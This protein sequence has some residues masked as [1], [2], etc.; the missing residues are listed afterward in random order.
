MNHAMRW[1]L[2]VAVLA[3]ASAAPAAEGQADGEK[4]AAEAGSFPKAFEVV[5]IGIPEGRGTSLAAYVNEKGQVV[6]L[7]NAAP[8]PSRAA[9]LWEKGKFVDIGM[10]HAGD[11]MKVGGI[12]DHGHITGEAEKVAAVPGPGGASAFVFK[13]GKLTKL[14]VPEGARYA[15]AGGSN[16]RG[17]IAGTMH[18]RMGGD[19]HPGAWI[20]GKWV[21]TEPKEGSAFGNGYGINEK[22][23][24]IGW[25]GVSGRRGWHGFVWDSGTFTDLGTLGGANSFAL[26]INEKTQIVGYTSTADKEFRGFLWEKGKMVALPPLEGN[27]ASFAHGINDHGEIVGWS[28][29]G[30]RKTAVVWI[31]GKPLDLNSLLPADSGWTVLEARDINNAR[32]I[33]GLAQNRQGRSMAVMLQPLKAAE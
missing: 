3:T 33:V 23:Q 7:T 5:E 9:Y 31:D 21:T 17:D 26:R 8:P 1:S 15:G 27:A 13:D 18:K 22:R 11:A 16:N 29:T 24:V 19:S 6:V 12:N 4:P 25:Y 10:I 20:D 2:I 32:Q 28:G 30:S 14:P